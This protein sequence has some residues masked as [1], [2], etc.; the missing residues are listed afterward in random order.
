M[1]GGLRVHN[2]ISRGVVNYTRSRGRNYYGRNQGEGGEKQ[3]KVPL[4]KPEPFSI[5]FLRRVGKRDVRPSDTEI[6]TRIII[7]DVVTQTRVDEAWEFS[8]TGANELIHS[9]SEVKKNDC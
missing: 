1:C 6:T 2:G 9:Q 3:G 8:Q 7:V 4:Q 5:N